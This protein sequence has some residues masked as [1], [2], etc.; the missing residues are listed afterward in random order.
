MW[1][2]GGD[3]TQITISS[4]NVEHIILGQLRAVWS[5]KGDRILRYCIDLSHSEMNI[6]RELSAPEIFILQSKVDILISSWDNKFKII[7][8]RNISLFGKDQA[9][10]YTSIAEEKMSSLKNIIS[11]SLQ[12]NSV[13]EWNILKD[14]S[15]YE[16]PLKFPE[17]EPRKKYVEPPEYEPPH[18]GFWDILFFR[19]K[20]KLQ[21]AVAF[22]NTIKT[23]WEV[24]EKARSAAYEAAV[25]GWKDREQVFWKQHEKAKSEFINEQLERNSAID[26][27]RVKVEYGDPEAI[28]QHA[29]LVLESSNYDGLFEK[30]FLIQY[31]LDDK[32]LMV[33]Y[34]LPSIDELPKVQ[35]V[36]F[37]K[38]TGEFKEKFI[39]EREEKANFELVAYQVSLRT[40][41]EIFEADI[42]N[43]IESIL[44]NGYVN[45]I[46]KRTGQDARS[47]LMSLHVIRDVFTSLD[48]SRIE[49]KSCFRNLKGVSAASLASFTAIP[50]VM[51]MDREDSRF[52]DG[53]VVAIDEGANLASM[54]WEEF[55]HLIRELFE[56]EF[57]ARR[58]EVKVTQAS[59]DGGVDAIAF[60]PDPI[61]GGKIVIQAK[62]YTRTV[63][64]SAVRDLFGTVMNE[65]ASKG[66]LVTTSDFGPDAYSFASGKPLTLLSGGNLLHLLERHGYKARIDLSQARADAAAS[67]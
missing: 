20:Q 30:S 9:D 36:K 62:R 4:S 60:D 55:E 5:T 29:T 37:I 35:E 24:E 17:V 26:N 6:H 65:G 64:V 58:G 41:H 34:D 42:Y 45:F 39:S 21:N 22:H 7:Q 57:L 2:L 49:P 23:N 16:M 44:F 48:L 56:K 67:R 59:R 52:V 47:C 15:Q 19:K 43:N 61:S 32:I 8:D 13:L 11:K 63:G 3:M 10:Y 18:I 53:K 27:L 40:L 38:S 51:E 66:I 54:P 50:P 1:Y 28:V 33:A 12:N 25:K 31:N 46:D 14:Q